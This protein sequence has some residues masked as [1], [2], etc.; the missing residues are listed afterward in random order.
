VS[1]IWL[2]VKDQGGVYQVSSTGRVRSK[3]KRGAR[4]VQWEN[5]FYL[6]LGLN[7]NG[8]PMVHLYNQ[9]TGKRRVSTVHRLMRETF[10]YWSMKPCVNHKNSIR[11]DNRIEN[12]E[13]CTYSENS[14]H[15]YDFGFS[16]GPPK[17]RKLTDEQVLAIYSDKRINSNPSIA[18]EFGIDTSSVCRIRN[19]E[20]YGWLTG[21]NN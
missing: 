21:K 2:D 13:P 1:E 9:K 17:T 7:K 19:G 11:H 4:R 18:R 15:A 10:F 8:Y 16:D 14:K 20:N 3:L 5:W 12:L 6:K